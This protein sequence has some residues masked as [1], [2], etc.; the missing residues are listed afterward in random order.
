MKTVRENLRQINAEESKNRIE[1]N[2]RNTIRKRLETNKL[3][4]T[5]KLICRALEG[6]DL[7]EGTSP[8]GDFFM[9]NCKRVVYIVYRYHNCKVRYTDESP[10]ED[11]RRLKVG[12]GF[13]LNRLDCETSVEGFSEMFTNFIIRHKLT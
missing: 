6:F 11:I 8:F 10:E 3:I 2:K 7:E 5:K 9:V 13:V 1:E 12:I 4:E